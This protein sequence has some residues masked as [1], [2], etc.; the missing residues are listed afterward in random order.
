MAFTSDLPNLVPSPVSDSAVADRVRLS[1]TGSIFSAIE[2]TVSKSVLNSTVTL[3]T[4]MTSELVIRAGLGLAGLE[5]E[6]YLLPKIVVAWISAF[7]FDGISGM[8]RGLTSSSSFAAS[9]PS[10]I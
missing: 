5:R 7:T 6:T 1:L 8:K 9:L 3:R 2:V 4:S 10:S